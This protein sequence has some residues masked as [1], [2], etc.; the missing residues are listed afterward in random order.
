MRIFPKSK[1]VFRFFVENKLERAYRFNNNY[2]YNM[3]S[4]FDDDNSD[5]IEKLNQHY[6]SF[7]GYK[8]LEEDEDLTP[9]VLE[10]KFKTLEEEYQ[11][12]EEQQSLL[13]FKDKNNIKEKIY[14]NL[15]LDA[16]IDDIIE[17]INYFIII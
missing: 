6:S 9:E 5:I 3:I 14:K 11:K 16:Q 12:E 10:R 13:L 15:I 17:F 1:S 7:I 4:M 8:I 2:F